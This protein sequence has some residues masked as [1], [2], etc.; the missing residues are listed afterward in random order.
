MFEE[1]DI[2]IGND[3]IQLSLFFSL[4]LRLNILRRSGLGANFESFAVRHFEWSCLATRPTERV[5]G[6][7]L[8]T[9]QN[10]AD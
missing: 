1:H 8:G 10:T 3:I 6:G 5:D 2:W 4:T 7:R 9:R